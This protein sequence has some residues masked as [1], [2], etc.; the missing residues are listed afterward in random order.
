MQTHLRLSSLF[1]QLLFDKKPDF[2]RADLGGKRYQRIL[3][4]LDNTIHHDSHLL[5]LRKVKKKIFH[6]P[7][8]SWTAVLTPLSQAQCVHMW[9]TSGCTSSCV[10]CHNTQP[11]LH[12]LAW[13]PLY[14]FISKSWTGRAYRLVQTRNFR[15][16]C[17]YYQ[18][19]MNANIRQHYCIPSITLNMAPFFYQ[20]SAIM[21]WF[22]GDHYRWRT[23]MQHRTLLKCIEGLPLFVFFIDLFQ[24]NKTN[25][26]ALH[27]V[28]EFSVMMRKKK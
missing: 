22:Q 27:G 23:W 15:N 10:K 17:K 24:I 14:P 1:S 18:T 4:V 11:L 28:A 9:S 25:Q 6:I 20:N 16:T 26:K 3:E 19:Q 5:E 7:S 12:L 13:S 8:T 2:L 21:L